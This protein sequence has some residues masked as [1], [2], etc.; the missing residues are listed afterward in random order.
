MKLRRHR[1]KKL[2]NTLFFRIFYFGL[3][4]CSYT[5]LSVCTTNAVR[6]LWNAAFSQDF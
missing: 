5:F 2:R 1:P 4:L 6:K 3:A